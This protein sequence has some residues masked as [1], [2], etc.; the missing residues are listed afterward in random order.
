[1]NDNVRINQQFLETNDQE[2]ACALLFNAYHKEVFAKIDRM[3]RNHIDPGVDA[4]DL[5]QETFIRAWK[6]RHEVREPEKL[7]GW[8]FTIATNLTRNEI[9]DA[10]RR[11]KTGHTFVESLE[12]LSV[13]EG[14][15]PYVTSLAETDAKQAEL[16]RYLVKQVLCL[17]QG[18]DRKV[19][20]LKGAGADMAEIVE[21]VGPNV[22]AV[23]KR[24]E[25]MLKWL[26]PI[27]LNLDAL[28]D[29]LPKEK[30]RWVMERYLDEQ[31]LSEIAKAI[32]TSR[33]KVE[34]TVKRVIKQWKKA[35]KDNPADPVS[36]MVKN[37]R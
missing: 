31:P 14:E 16:E 20:E 9:R 24:W 21:T 17:L 32:P 8:L 35:A 37:E 2:E 7:R 3:M 28:V 12:S 5:A 29:C 15:L 36:E 22:E 27:A 23:Q 10:E 6:K 11:R 4:E 13:N 34:E 30:D 19:A 33:S 25:R 18:K 1:M 26:I